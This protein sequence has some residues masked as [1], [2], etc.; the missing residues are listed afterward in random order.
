[1]KNSAITLRTLLL[2]LFVTCCSI[3]AFADDMLEL[4]S[5]LTKLSAAVESTVRY[6][7]PPKDLTNEELLKLSTKHD[8]DLLQPFSAY[9]VRVKAQDRHA[10]LLVCSKDGKTGLLEDA[11]CTAKLDQHLWGKDNPLPCEFT[12]AASSA[13]ESN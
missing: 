5:A 3:P 11:G 7:N 6:K 9:L 1:M 8:P 13:C 4:S 12:L 10:I 2:V